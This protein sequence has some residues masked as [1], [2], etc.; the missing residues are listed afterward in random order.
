MKRFS[1]NVRLATELGTVMGITA[2]AWTLLGLWLGLKLDAKLGTQP[3][4][5]ILLLIAGAAAGQLA[6]FRLVLQSRPEIEAGSR[7]AF[8]LKDA[9][10]VVRLA[11]ILLLLLAIPILLGLVLGVWLDG[12][13]GT[14]LVFTLVLSLGCAIAGLYG[15]IRIARSQP[16]RTARKGDRGCSSVADQ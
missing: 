6:I 9:L 14:H 10:R 5:T 16:S 7:H 4:A 8:D 2:A 12:L 11:L 13:L 15:A 3:I 1:H